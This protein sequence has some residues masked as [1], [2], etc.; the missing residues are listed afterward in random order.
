MS[1]GFSAFASFGMLSFSSA[2]TRAEMIYRSM[3]AAKIGA[4][5]LKPGSYQEAKVYAQAMGIARGRYTLQRAFNQQFPLK[6][7]EMLPALEENWSIVPSE[8]ASILD[9][10]LA[11]ASA[12]MLVRGATREAITAGLQ[13]I[14]G[15]HFIALRILTDTETTKEQNTD[16]YGPLFNRVDIPFKLIQL[17]D[18]V[19]TIGVPL[20]IMYENA[21]LTAGALLIQKNEKL[22]IEPEVPGQAEIVTVI[23]ATA[24]T[25]T[26]TFTKSHDEG[27][28]ATTQ[29]WVNWTST[30]RSYFVVVDAFA[31]LDSEMVRR[32][33]DFMSKVARGVSK[34][35][36][37]EPI[38][39]G[40]SFCGPFTLE[41]SPLGMTPIARLD[42]FPAVTPDFELLP[43]IMTTMGGRLYAFGRNL[44]SVIQVTLQS[45]TPP[46]YVLPLTVVSDYELDLGVL[47]GTFVVPVGAGFIDIPVDFYNGTTIRKILR[48]AQAPEAVSYVYPANDTMGPVTAYGTGLLQ[49][50]DIQ[51][52]SFSF[53]AGWVI[54]DD[55]TITNIVPTNFY[56][57][58]GHHAMTF[59]FG[60]GSTIS[61]DFLYS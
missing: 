24:T 50:V 34:W 37:I 54:T 43:M 22:L 10:Q 7:V 4:F 49:V 60:D 14:L 5:D 21:D 16:A 23:A 57:T 46:P 35:S 3:Y 26:A 12:M 31:A 8:T 2:P 44:S 15:T 45:T 33:N 18:P 53:A 27:A 28:F 41:Y 56:G 32:V 36:I 42:I 1:G 39:P 20:T 19:A 13:A 25:F 17:P 40:V 47:P 11:V 58:A 9:R 6:A 51:A 29:N 48:I 61:V 30:Q 38:N 55:S 52:N 59:V